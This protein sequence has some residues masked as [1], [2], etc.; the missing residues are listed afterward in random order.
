MRYDLIIWLSF[1]F[2]KCLILSDDRCPL[3]APL[4]KNSENNCVYEPY[5]ANDHQIDNKIIKIQ[6][7][8]GI[9][10]IGPINSQYMASDISSNGDL[11]IE[12]NVYGHFEF[13]RVRYFYGIKSNGMPFFYI[14]GDN[15]F[16][17]QIS[18]QSNSD[19]GQFECQ[20]NR[21]RLI[22]GKE[23]Y[24]TSSFSGYTIDFID[25]YNNRIIGKSQSDLFEYTNWAS[26]FYSI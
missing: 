18:L 11:I 7:L 19:I 6:W 3:N 1:I 24:L 13:N 2:Q 9:N 15:K 20:M 8:N 26:R 5:I 23:Y 14:Q 21:I 16:T 25:F 17:N 12:S 10:Q 4:F 22:D